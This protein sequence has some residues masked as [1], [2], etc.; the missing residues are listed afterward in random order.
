M[1]VGVSMFGV[2]YGHQLMAHALGGRVDYHPRG[3]EVGCQRIRLSSEAAND[4]LLAGSPQTFEAHL[5]H[6]QSIVKLPPH[7]QVLASS[8]HDAYQI[9]RY[10]PN[11]VSTQ[12]HPEFTPGITEACIRRRAD[13]L[14]EEG[15][16]VD[17][18]I[19]NL[20]DTQEARDLLTRFVESA[21]LRGS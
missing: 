12:F 18:L 8:A 5:M 13:A 21:A 19:G 2:C 3:R 14:S 16:N 6:E 20:R 1:T 11:A 9:V 17:E 15:L 7:A 4:A 10:G